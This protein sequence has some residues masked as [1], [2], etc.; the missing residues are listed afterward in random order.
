[1]NI[2]PGKGSN[3]VNSREKTSGIGGNRNLSWGGQTKWPYRCGLKE[4]ARL[5]SKGKDWS[6][7]E[8]KLLYTRKTGFQELSLESK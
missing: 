1:M 8:K 5:G 7:A 2:F 6:T 4:K 3:E